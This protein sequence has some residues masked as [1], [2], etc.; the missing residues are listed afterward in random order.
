MMKLSQNLFAETLLKTLGG[1]N[2]PATAQ[3]GWSS[4]R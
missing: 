2:P 3:G 4:N 1:S